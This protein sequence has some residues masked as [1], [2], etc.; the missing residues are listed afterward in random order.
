M[1]ALDEAPWPRA[2]HSGSRWTSPP[3]PRPT[4]CCCSTTMPLSTRT[5]CSGSSRRRSASRARSRRRRRLQGR[6]LGSS[7]GACWTSVDPATTSVTPTRRCS[8]TRSTRGSSTASSRCW[9]SRRPR[10]SS[11]ARHGSEPG[12]LDE[13]LAVDQQG[14]DLCWRARLVGF[15]VVMMPRARVRHRADSHRASTRRARRATALATKRTVTR[16]RR[17]SRTTGCCR[18]SGSRP[19]TVAR[20]RSPAVPHLVATIRRGLR[21]AGR[22]GLERRTPRRHAVAAP[23]RPARAQGEGSTDPSVHGDGGAPSSSVVPDGGAHPR[24]TTRDRRPRRWRG[25]RR[26]GCAIERRRLV[27][28]HPV[29]V[30][31]FLGIVLGALVV[32]GLLGSEVLAGGVL[33]AFPPRPGRL[34]GRS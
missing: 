28:S 9:R 22:L 11:P 3:R 15:R 7:H 24:G 30:A 10:C 34:S 2:A 13:R 26:S 23:T 29:I 14:L 25:G 6:R 4:S 16:S 31:S 8:P 1:I 5:R 20:F 21:R 19:S 32:R 33:P 17:C 18:C 27:G 12:L